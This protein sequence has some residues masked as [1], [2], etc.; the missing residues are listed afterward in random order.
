MRIVTDR[1]AVDAGR[2]GE[3]GSR[4]QDLLPS[5]A[6]G[7]GALSLLPLASGVQSLQWFSTATALLKAYNIYPAQNS[8]PVWHRQVHGSNVSLDCRPLA[9]FGEH[10]VNTTRILGAT[11]E[12]STLQ[13]SR[14]FLL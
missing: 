1:V 4:S 8:C 10:R 14:R 9:S 2:R 12:F 11:L 13:S 7:S 5:I 3:G 6:I